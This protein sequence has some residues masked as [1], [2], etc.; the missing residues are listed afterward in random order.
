MNMLASDL[1]NPE[2]A[3]PIDPDALLH[4]DFYWCE[5]VDG[6]ESNV[7]QKRVTLP[8][9]PFV[10]IM[11]PGDQTSILEVPVRE[12]HKRRWPHKWLYFQMQ[13]GLIDDGAQIPGWKIEEWDEIKDNAELVR[14]L[15]FMRFHTVEQIA[16]ASDAQI[17]NIGLGAYGLREKAKAAL[18][19]H[20]SA[21]IKEEIA[22]RDKTIAEQGEALRRLQEQMGFLMNPEARSS[23]PVA[24]SRAPAPSEPGEVGVASDQA[25]ALPEQTKHR[26][27][28]KGSKNKRKG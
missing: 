5:P 2:F 25:V 28:K 21:G 1:N 17:Q 15:K 11:K 27:R 24:E 19:Q 22:A 14:G 16:G 6:W 12:D 3:N 13:E 10:R 23:T 18:R 9:Q 8:K 26:G 4:V 7:Q 20:M